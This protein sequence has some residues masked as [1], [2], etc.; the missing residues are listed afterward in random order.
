MGAHFART[1]SCFAPEV[2]NLISIYFVYTKKLK[3]IFFLFSGQE[4]IVR[5]YDVNKRRLL[6]RFIGHKAPVHRT[7]FTSDCLHVASFSDD[8]T[9]AIWD[10]PTEKQLIT[11]D[12]LHTDYI[13]AGAVSPVSPNIVLSGSYDKTVKMY[14]IRQERAVFTVNHD[15]PVES[16]L[17]LPSG[18]IFLS[19]GKSLLVFF[20]FY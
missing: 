8:K 19:A 2:I 1:D 10:I 14:D 20:F 13:R 9:T 7:Y 3:T 18:G 16:L 5:V 4:P 17:F 11:F 15:A 12:G 6:R